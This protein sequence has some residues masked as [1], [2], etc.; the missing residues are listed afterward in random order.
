MGS[1]LINKGV[2]EPSY[3]L[4]FMVQKHNY[5]CTN[6]IEGQVT[7][8][9][10]FLRQ[11]CIA[12]TFSLGTGSAVSCRFWIVVVSFSFVSSFFFVCFFFFDFF[13]NV[14]VVQQH[15]VCLQCFYVFYSLLWLILASYCCK[16]KGCLIFQFSL[17]CQGLPCGPACHLSWRAFHVHLK[18]VQSPVFGCNAL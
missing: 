9:P 17:I 1:I 3:N 10:C 5:F 12:M 6:L 11:D 13:S 18:D 14:L 15:I 7:E 8:F 4:K 2:F 16:Q